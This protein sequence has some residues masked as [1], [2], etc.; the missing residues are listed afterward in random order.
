[1][2]SDEWRK[3]LAGNELSMVKSLASGDPELL[4]RPIDGVSPLMQALYH[5]A[6]DVAAWLREY[7]I[8]LTVHEAAAL[9]DVEAL[10]RILGADPNCKNEHARDGF[11]PL[12]LAAFFGHPRAVTLLAGKGADVNALAENPTRVRPLHSAV[13]SGDSAT[14]HA[15]LDGGPDVNARQA[16]GFTALHAAALHG[17]ERMVDL[18]L[19]ARAD[20]TIAADDG[21]KAADFARDGGFEALAGRLG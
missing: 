9:G 15:V 10:E 11:T 5:R 3:A 6:M 2:S 14:V 17:D 8:E 13:A 16:G 1:M 12:H 18:L 7:A 19:K 20:T 21:R 4:A